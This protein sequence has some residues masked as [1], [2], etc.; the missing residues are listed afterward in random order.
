M[1]CRVQD[2]QRLDMYRDERAERRE[3][4]LTNCSTFA[5]KQ[6]Q[7]RFPHR[8]V[9]CTVDLQAH[10]SLSF[11]ASSCRAYRQLQDSAGQLS[12]TFWIRL[13]SWRRDVLVSL[14]ET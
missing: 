2:I 5:A 13:F 6:D 1:R 9:G 7:A 12:Y 3:S 4:R 14:G 8:V 11:A 10:V